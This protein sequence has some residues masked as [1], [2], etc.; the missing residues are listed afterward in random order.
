MV[1]NK[2][3][4][5]V[6]LIF[7]IG[8]GLFFFTRGE[9]FEIPSGETRPFTGDTMDSGME[10]SGT[11]PIDRRLSGNTERLAD[12]EAAD[13]QQV[14]GSFPR[15]SSREM[16]ITDGVKHSIPLDEILSGGP[17]KDGIPSIDDPKFTSTQQA[18]AFLEDDSVGL[19]VVHKGEARFY[20]Y[21]ILV[22]HEIVN[23]TIQ[24]DP[25]LVTYCPLCMTG[26]VFDRTIDG[27]AVEF[28][29]SGRLWQ[30]NLLMYNR[31]KDA[32]KESLWSQVL[33]EA[34]LGEFTG[35]KLSVLPADTI[36]YG[37]WKQGHPDTK[38]LTRETGTPRPYGRDPYEGYYTN[39]TV[40]FGATFT[41]NRLAPKDFVLGVEV[42]GKFKAYHAPALPEGTTTDTFA[43][44][45]IT[46]EKSDIGEVRMFI[47][48]DRQRLPY[49]GGFWFSWAAVHPETALYK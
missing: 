46:I 23:D 48:E 13:T 17:P 26:V 12:A 3:A 33:G 28:G 45:T 34:V 30:S 31:S 21:Q 20:P 47:G 49:I 14:S 41:D 43:G 37:Q 32:G 8:I 19:G 1:T 25:I 2:L 24:G 6:V 35:R 7:L 29:V 10:T 44:R 4:I 16:F 15:T 36:R 42:D 22:W 27:E 11:S 18:D 9:Q 40:S 38:V 5:V 39:D